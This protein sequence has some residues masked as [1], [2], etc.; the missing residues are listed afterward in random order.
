[1]PAGP[2]PPRTRIFGVDIG[3]FS[4]GELQLCGSLVERRPTNLYVLVVGDQK[5]LE[6]CLRARINPHAG[7][8]DAAARVRTKIVRRYIGPH[9]GI[10]VTARRTISQSML[11]ISSCMSR[12]WR[13]AWRDERSW[14]S[15]QADECKAIEPISHVTWR[16]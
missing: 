12:V 16:G 13:V 2:V 4:L 1:M 7:Y 11:K 14:S 3:Q 8:S 9:L 6:V 5:L 15:Q 10:G